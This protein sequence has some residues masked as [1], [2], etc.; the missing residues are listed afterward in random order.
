MISAATNETRTTRAPIAI[1][2]SV[3]PWAE[4]SGW[5]N[6]RPNSCRANIFMSSLR[7]Q[8]LSPRLALQNKRQMYDLLFRATAET[9]QRLQPIRSAWA[10]QIGF[11]CIL[12]TWGQTL[13]AHPHLHC[14][15]PG[16]WHLPGRSAVGWPAVHASSS[17]A[18]TLAPVSPALPSLPRAGLHGR[19]AALSRSATALVRS[20]PTSLV[21]W[22]RCRKSK[23]VVYAKP[24]FGG[25]ERV[26]DYLGR[27][28]HRVAIS[29]NRLRQL[30]DGQVTFAYKDYKARTAAESS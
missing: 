10:S 9:L 29:N 8:N 23:W 2:P 6:V 24:P 27:Y 19:K 13:T 11:F 26:L 5:K 15:V 21:T 1:A 12:H 16:W 18:R 20:Q 7:C 14:V 17:R 25:P 4:P 28:T 30:K 22:L 3:S